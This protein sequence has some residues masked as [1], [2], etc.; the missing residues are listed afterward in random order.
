M[1]HIE[2]KKH[3]FEKSGAGRGGGMILPTTN[4]C[5]IFN[6]GPANYLLLCDF[7]TG[8]WLITKQICGFFIVEKQ[9]YDTFCQ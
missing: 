9:V 8:V 1:K 3:G 5:V 2:E 7:S 4:Y 6:R